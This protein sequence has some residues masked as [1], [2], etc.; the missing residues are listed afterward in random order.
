MVNGSGLHKG[1]PVIPDYRWVNDGNKY[2]VFP[3]SFRLDDAFLK[4]LQV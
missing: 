1:I 4:G 2:R 3:A